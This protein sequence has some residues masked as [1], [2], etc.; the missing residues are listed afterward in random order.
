[1]T[2]KIK[3]EIIEGDPFEGACCKPNYSPASK[4]NEENIRKM[5]TERSEIVSQIEREYAP[6]L[7]ITRKI[8]GDGPSPVICA[9]III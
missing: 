2:P 1:M 9:T 4:N 5:L 6:K 3:L 7:T 8:Y